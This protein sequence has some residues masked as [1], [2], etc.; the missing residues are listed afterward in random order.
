MN[1]SLSAESLNSARL[2][3]NR[4]K[5]QTIESDHIKKEHYIIPLMRFFQDS[6]DLERALEIDRQECVLQADYEIYNL[7]KAMIGPNKQHLELTDFR[8]ILERHFSLNVSFE[9]L[10]LGIRRQFPLM[11]RSNVD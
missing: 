7:F 2:I 1:S 3:A 6:I 8:M 10:R 9:D 5:A 11:D 4:L